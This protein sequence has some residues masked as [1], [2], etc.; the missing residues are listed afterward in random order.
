[1]VSFDDALE[2]LRNAEYFLRERKYA[3]SI[4][5]TQLCVEL[6]VKCLF[7][8]LSVEYPKRH[9]IEDKCFSVLFKHVGKIINDKY[10]TKDAN[11][12]IARARVLLA[13][14]STLRNFTEYGLSEVSAKDIF[15]STRMEDLAKSFYD[16]ANEI[17]WELWGLTRHLS[18]LKR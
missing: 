12:K 18:S 9:D 4:L 10:L 11:T 5:N 17:Y 2:K 13:S 15:N 7:Q 14:L 1:M 8:G 6:S 3:D 16:C